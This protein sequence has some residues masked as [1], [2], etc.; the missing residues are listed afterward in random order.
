MVSTGGVEGTVNAFYKRSRIKQQ[1]NCDPTR[2]DETVTSNAYDIGCQ[3]RPQNLVDLRVRAGTIDN[4]LLQTQR[5]GQARRLCEFSLRADRPPISGMR[6]IG[7]L[8]P[9]ASLPRSARSN[10]TPASGSPPQDRPRRP[11]KLGST[12]KV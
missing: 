9:A 7:G 10:N 2:R 4:R 3:R 11:E 6:M 1:F 12:V 5:V 8:Q